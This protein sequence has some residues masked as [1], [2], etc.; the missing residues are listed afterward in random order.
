MSELLFNPALLSQ[1]MTRTLAHHYAI[2]DTDDAARV[3]RTLELWFERYPKEHQ[4]E[5]RARFHGS[6][7]E[8]LSALAEL[9][10]HELICCL[11]YEVEVHPKM[12]SGVTRTPD[13][14]VRRSGVPAFYVEVR[15]V[16]PTEPELRSGSQAS[17][18]LAAL[19]NIR[20]DC[21]NLGI[22][23]IASPDEEI[24][25]PYVAKEIEQWLAGLDP[26]EAEFGIRPDSFRC[27]VEHR[28]LRLRVRALPR[29][30]EQ[31]FSRA[32]VVMIGDEIVK[33]DTNAAR[34]SKK[35]AKKR[36]AYK[37]DLPY[38]VVLNMLG[39]GASWEDVQAAAFGSE[40]VSV[41]IGPDGSITE[42]EPRRGRDGALRLEP[43]SPGNSV[44]GVIGVL[45]LLPQQLQAVEPILFH[46]PL[47]E[48]P[49][50][51]KWW[52]MLQVPSGIDLADVAG[53]PYVRAHTILNLDRVIVRP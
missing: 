41:S 6:D 40:T 15:N 2:P 35:L 27:T 14:L 5:L 31:R 8:F 3:S 23:W 45:Q 7:S 34:G 4:I 51:Q 39:A 13:F 46:H 42:V 19:K 32:P 22:T 49:F 12:P 48:R 38:L 36:S 53:R 50:P 1:R 24:S 43:N 44:S 28:G 33:L 30:I 16:D 29:L 20:S 18:M 26:V 21:F 25:W 10:F 37:P 11:G 52:P 47:T 17:A 9:Y